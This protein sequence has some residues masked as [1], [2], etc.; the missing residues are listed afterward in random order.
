LGPH[1]NRRHR[2]RQWRARIRSRFSRRGSS[3]RWAAYEF[4]ARLDHETPSEPI[5][6]DP[7]QLAIEKAYETLTEAR[8]TATEIVQR[9]RDQAE[10]ILETATT[11]AD[12]I[13]SE[14]R[15]LSQDFL[16]RLRG[17]RQRAASYELEDPAVIVR[18]LMTGAPPRPDVSPG[19]AF[20]AGGANGAP[21]GSQ[22]SAAALFWATE[23]FGDQ[24]DPGPPP[25]G[26]PLGTE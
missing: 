18:R 17:L 23:A 26:P 13:T 14:A 22:P 8:R 4:R 25:D 24:S 3:R 7:A 16:D 6:Q 19:G 9:A 1:G 5:S 2:Y 11:Q 21:N 15:T 10:V 12:S 20:A